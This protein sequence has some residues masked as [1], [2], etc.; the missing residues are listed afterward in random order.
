[1]AEFVSP[2]EDL[3]YDVDRQAK[4]EIITIM[5]NGDADH[6]EKADESGAGRSKRLGVS[7]WL[8]IIVLLALLG[9]A[10]WFAVGIWQAT[11]ETEISTHG[12]IAMALGII[13]TILVGAG[14]MALVFW[15]S[16]KGFD[17]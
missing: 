16:R 4:F 5:R 10:I 13:V 17:R 7:G 12:K 15:S 11:E 8:T 9:G 6:E 3:L 1:M 14:L 2:S